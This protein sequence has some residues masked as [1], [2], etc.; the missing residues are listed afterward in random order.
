MI[1]QSK[2]KPGRVWP[3]RDVSKLKPLSVADVVVSGLSCSH[4]L[5]LG[6][7]YQVLCRKP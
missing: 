1:L 6:A 5:P 4:G 3:M 7:Q 2:R